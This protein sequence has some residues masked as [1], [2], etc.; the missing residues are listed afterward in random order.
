[1]KR[2]DLQEF[3]NGLFTYGVLE[4]LWVQAKYGKS[5][6]QLR[7]SNERFGWTCLALAGLSLIVGITSAILHNY[8]VACICILVFMISLFGFRSVTRDLGADR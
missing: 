1:M 2:L 3:H 6:L 5:R 8:E 7:Q 4:E